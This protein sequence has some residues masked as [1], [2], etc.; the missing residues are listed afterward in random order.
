MSAIRTNVLAGHLQTANG[1]QALARW[2]KTAIERYP[3]GGLLPRIWELRMNLTPYD[4]AYVA[5]AETMLCPLLT[6]DGRIGRAPGLR[7]EIQLVPR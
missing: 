1:A 7:C 5:L 2:S 3:A 6:A 4:A